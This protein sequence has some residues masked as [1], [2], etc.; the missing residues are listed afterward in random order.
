MLRTCW[1]IQRPWPPLHSGC[2]DL[3]GA[4]R[5]NHRQAIKRYWTLE[6]RQRVT[7]HEVT[8]ARIEVDGRHAYDHGTY[9]VS[10][11]RNGVAWG[12]FRGK[13]VVVWR[14]EL[15]QGWRIHL[16]MWNSGADQGP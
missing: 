12:P 15:P 5:C 3:S 8:P 13:Y 11:E 2:G 10:G 6:P 9:K 14:K 1:A 7:L 4:L 16:D